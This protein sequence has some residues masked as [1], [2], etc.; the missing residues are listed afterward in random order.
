VIT[1][2]ASVI[3]RAVANRF[4]AEGATVVGVDIVDH[5]VGD[6]A[7]RADLIDEPQVAAMYD[8][9]VAS[10][11]RLDVIYNNVGLMDRGDQSALSTELDTWRRVQDA[12]LTTTFRSCKHGIRH[13]QSTQP[14][15][16][17]SSTPR[18]SSPTS[19][20]RRRR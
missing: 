9:V 10:Y 3:G 17:S 8:R 18:H 15:G 20:R 1:G 13:L 16:G 2:A 11:G 19:A 12:D 5:T 6:L 14:A 7:M 4:R